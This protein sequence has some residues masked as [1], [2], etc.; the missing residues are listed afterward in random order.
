MM[1]DAGFNVGR[2]VIRKQ[3]P[4]K[5]WKSARAVCQWLFHGRSQRQRSNTCESKPCVPS[6]RI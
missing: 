6:K 4:R 5:R 2:E 3:C 1:F